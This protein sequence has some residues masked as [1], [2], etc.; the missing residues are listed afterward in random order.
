MD[1]EFDIDLPA[2]RPIV[3]DTWLNQFEHGAITEAL[4]F[5][6]PQVEGSFR[7]WGGAV[8]GQFLALE[9]PTKIVKTWRTVDFESWMPDTRVTMRFLE[10]PNGSRISIRH[11]LIPVQMFAQFRFAW[12]EYYPP[13][14]QRYFIQRFIP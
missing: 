1:I 13:R 7:L 8:T 9:R 14:L 12:M 4:A 3:Y 5:I 2:P 10:R 11:E 6:T